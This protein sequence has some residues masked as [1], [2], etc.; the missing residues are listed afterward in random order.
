MNDQEFA[1]E[2]RVLNVPQLHALWRMQ[3]LHAP[4]ESGGQKRQII[5]AEARRRKV[6]DVLDRTTDYL[7]DE[8]IADFELVTRHGD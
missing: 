7:L 3:G 1:N 4:G 8:V 5:V 6:Q 2:L